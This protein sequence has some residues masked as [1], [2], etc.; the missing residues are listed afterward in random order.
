[1]SEERANE[2]REKK[3]EERRERYEFIVYI[4]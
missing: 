1:V 3:G 4:A 2:E